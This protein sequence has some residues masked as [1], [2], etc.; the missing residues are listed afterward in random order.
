MDQSSFLCE[1]VDR[2]GKSTLINNLQKVFGYHLVV[3]YEKPK[4]LNYYQTAIKSRNPS[5]DQ[6]SIDRMSLREY[7]YHSFVGMFK[8]FTSNAPVICDRA[9]L[10]EVVYSPRY[11]GYDGDYVF[12]LESNARLLP[13]YKE[14][15]LVLLTTSDFS[16]VQDDGMSF[17]FSKK[18]EEQETF[19]DAFEKSTIKN[20]MLID[21]SNK[22]G[23]FRDASDIAREVIYGKI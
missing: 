7:Q 2:L 6:S 21:V 23:G 5:L 10:G 4:L 3:H 14:P 8:L 19:I 17:D 11:R 18:E 9:H 12:I 1:G 13:Y 22:C 16:I 15:R 20:K